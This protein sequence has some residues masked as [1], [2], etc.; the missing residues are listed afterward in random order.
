MT[1]A[2]MLFTGPVLRADWPWGPLEPSAYGLI[3]IDP[4]WHFRLYSERGED[5]S[6]Q[7]HYRTMGLDAIAALPVAELAAEHAV[8]W[9]WATAPMI[10]QQIGLVTR[11]G[12]RLATTGVWV[13]TTINGKLAF[14]TGYVLRNAHEPFVLGIRGEPKLSRSVRSVIMGE[15]REH[16]AKPEAA[17]VAAEALFPGAGRRVELFSRRSRPG[18]EA[19]GDEVGSLDESLPGPSAAHQQPAQATSERSGSSV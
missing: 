7:A 12:F 2:P 1:A 15:V 19:W 14:G 10:D 18:W 13:K 17:Y 6:A 5:K 4:P 8:I 9:M 11:W 3:M 16:S